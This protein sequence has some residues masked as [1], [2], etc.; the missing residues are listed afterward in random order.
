MF[1]PRVETS[2]VATLRAQPGKSVLAGFVLL[3]TTPVAA[4]LLVISILALPIGL[5]LGDCYAMALFGGVLSTAF[6]GRC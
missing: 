1:L 2:T 4:F 5:A 3:V 6:R